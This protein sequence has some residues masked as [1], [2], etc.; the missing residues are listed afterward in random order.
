MPYEAIKD[1]PASIREA[2]PIEAQEIYLREFNRTWALTQ[3]PMKR[4]YGESQEA[5][6][7]KAAWK[8]V[9][10]DY[11]KDAFGNWVKKI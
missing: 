7:N 8:A 2:L 1:L 4:E 10:N 9:M 6:A 3:D 11:E 5:A